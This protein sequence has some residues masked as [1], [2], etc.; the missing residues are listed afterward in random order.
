[1]PNGIPDTLD[2]IDAQNADPPGGA[3]T[4]GGGPAP[5]SGGFTDPNDPAFTAAPDGCVRDPSGYLICENQGN[6]GGG[7]TCIDPNTGAIVPCHRAD[8]QDVTPNDP[9]EI[10]NALNQLLGGGGQGGG[11][12]PQNQS[13]GNLQGGGGGGGGG[14]QINSTTQGEQINQQILDLFSQIVSQDAQNPHQISIDPRFQEQFADIQQ[15]IADQQGQ[16]AQLDP[17]TR[18][19]FQAMLRQRQADFDQ[20]ANQQRDQLLT[21]LFG[22]GV[23]QSSIA[24]SRA[25][26]FATDRARGRDA[27]Q[28]DV[29]GQELETRQF[30][31][32]HGLQSL[33][34]RANVLN[35][36][37]Q[38]ALQEAGINA[39]LINQ[40]R[41]RNAGILTDALGFSAQRDTARIGAN[42]QIAS[43]RIGAQSRIQAAQIGARAQ[44]EA[45]RLGFATDTYRTQTAIEQFFRSQAQQES[46]FDRRLRL[47][48]ELGFSSLS[49][50]DRARQDAQQQQTLSTFASI[51]LGLAVLSDMRWKCDASV[52]GT[53][54]PLSVYEYRYIGSS[55]VFVGLSAQEVQHHYPGN[56]VD[57]DGVLMIQNRAA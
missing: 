29:F 14:N 11:G 21:Q 46:Q 12:G 19:Q 30:L 20:Q 10:L 7:R 26:Q 9:L 54:G 22:S 27:I 35:A 23:Q 49:Q 37:Y 43:A 28:S 24:A 32:S 50:A 36:E 47:D 52:V 18:E 57:N 17:E 45:A 8:G 2:Q 51:A 33:Q 56:V 41:Q 31:T 15:Q 38:G 1:M 34:T 16:L 25:G 40:Q 6:S 39:E 4:G 44:S 3:P 13:G 48:Q 53:V 55:D 5:G 42:A